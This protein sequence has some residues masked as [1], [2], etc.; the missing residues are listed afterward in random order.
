MHL[1][2]QAVAGEDILDQQGQVATVSIFKPDLAN[3]SPGTGGGEDRRKVGPAP[4]L[5]DIMGRKLLHQHEF[6][7]IRMAVF[8]ISH[9]APVNII[10]RR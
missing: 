1:N 6:P 3:P 5:F 10:P 4:W 8:F 9:G 2:R 7:M